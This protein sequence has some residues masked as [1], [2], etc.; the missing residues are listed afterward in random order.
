MISSAPCG[1]KSSKPCGADPRSAADPLAGFSYGAK[2]PLISRI[3]SVG[4]VTNTLTDPFCPAGTIAALATTF[5]PNEFSVETVGCEFL[6]NSS[7]GAGVFDECD[8]PP[9]AR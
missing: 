7:D 9:P 5:P 8:S 4:L 2:Y 3:T 6:R 1:V